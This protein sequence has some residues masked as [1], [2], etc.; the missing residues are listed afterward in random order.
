MG[1]TE[2]TLSQDVVFDILSSPRRR[3]VLYH[4]RTTG[5]PV[6]LTNLAEKV[7]AWENDTAVSEITEQERK[8]VYV[9]L[10]Q[11][12]IPRLAD[13]GLIDYDKESGMIGLAED[14][15]AIDQYLQSSKT[16]VPWHWIYLGLAG[17]STVLLGLTAIVAFIPE[18][19][20]V[21]VVLLAF[22]VTVTA[23]TAVRF[24]NRQTVPQE[25]QR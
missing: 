12:H 9:S 1:T 19:A 5:T 4:L 17:L 13:V 20:A 21:A 15:A 10:Y 3:Y 14:T 24:S 6:E 18:T 23:H 25:L 11:T 2:S 22:I 16:T 7:A 8:R